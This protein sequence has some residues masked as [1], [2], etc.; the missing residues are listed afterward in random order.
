MSHGTPLKIAVDADKVACTLEGE[1]V[2]PGQDLEIL[3]EGGLWLLARFEWSGDVEFRPRLH[4]ACGGAWEEMDDP[5]T[6]TF[7]IPPEISFEIPREALV[8]RPTDAS[9]PRPRPPKP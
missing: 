4:V 2:F 6:S 1:P 8:R 7:P 3:L 5:E 9:A